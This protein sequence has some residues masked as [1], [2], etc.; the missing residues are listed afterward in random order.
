LTVLPLILF[1]SS[2]HVIQAVGDFDSDQK[3]GLNTFVVKFGKDRSILVAGLLCLASIFIFTSYF[4]L[5]LIP[6]D[7]LMITIVVFPLFLPITYYFIRVLGKP[8]S[9]NVLRLTRITRRL[10]PLILL[11]IWVFIFFAK[12]F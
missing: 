7:Y 6:S 3:A 10:G 8:S 12:R 1:N 4:F 2:L 5:S 11:S 9:E